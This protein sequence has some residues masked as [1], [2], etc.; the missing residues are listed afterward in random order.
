MCSR[1]N[2]FNLV[3]FFKTFFA[4]LWVLTSGSLNVKKPFSDEAFILIQKRKYFDKNHFYLTKNRNLN[5]AGKKL[6]KTLREIKKLKFKRIA[7][8]KI[9]NKGM[10]QTINDR[11][12]RASKI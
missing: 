8:Q 5:E 2:F 11:L 4:F 10:G 1:F 3:I 7:V 6:Y 9:P 12:R